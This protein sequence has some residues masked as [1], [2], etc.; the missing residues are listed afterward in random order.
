MAVDNEDLA[1]APLR[2]EN[3]AQP[4]LS[5]QEF[6]IT[7]RGLRKVYPPSKGIAAQEALKG[8]DLNVPRGSIFGLLGPNGAGKS[9]FINILAGMTRK[10]SGS[11]MVWGFDLDS[12]P[13]QA[14]ASIG[15]VPQELNVDAFFSPKEALDM[16]A[17]LYGVSPKH[18]N[19]KEIL[20]LVHLEDKADAYARTLSGGMRRR[21][22]VAKSMVHYPPVLILDEPTAGVDVELRHELWNMMERLNATGVT[23]VLT[24]HY[25]EEAQ[26][27]CDRIAIINT[28]EVV[29]EDKT[30]ELLKLID[31]KT[32]RI[33][34][35]S[36]LSVLPPQVESLS[37]ERVN[38]SLDEGV[39]QIDYHTNEIHLNELLQAVTQAGVE[40]ADIST[41]ESALED[42]FLHLTHSGSHSDSGRDS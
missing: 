5:G 20:R 8:I 4:S 26:A 7:A 25:L 29:A 6:A 18:R 23:I 17:G 37:S 36:P 31:Y 34:P 40:V 30:S 35:V 28:G 14:R 32:I 22:M 13:R 11:V 21:L 42:V 10:T 3:R 9:T 1:Q 15:I 39:L 19:T 12:N 41:R 2:E 16:Q 33:T 24:T 27:L 38:I